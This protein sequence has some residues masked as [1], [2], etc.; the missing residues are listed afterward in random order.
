MGGEA[1]AGEGRRAGGRGRDGESEEDRHSRA[2]GRRDA[3][4]PRISRKVRQFSLCSG[5]VWAISCPGR[6]LC[7][8]SASLG[9][10]EPPIQFWTVMKPFAGANELSQFALRLLHT[11]ANSVPSDSRALVFCAQHCSSYQAR[12]SA[13]RGCGQTVLHPH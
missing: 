10:E 4:H 7:S 8:F 1:Q 12:F 5:P 2:F 3:A 11:Q 6:L 13:A 9:S